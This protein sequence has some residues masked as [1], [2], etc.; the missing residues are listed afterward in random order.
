MWGVE[1]ERSGR[2]N[3]HRIQYNTNT[4]TDTLPYLRGGVG[5]RLIQRRPPPLPPEVLQRLD[6]LRVVLEEDLVVDLLCVW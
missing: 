1:K 6:A 2:V 3:E 4:N 5:V